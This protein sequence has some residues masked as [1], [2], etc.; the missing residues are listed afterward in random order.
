MSE[1]AI[2]RLRLPED[3]TEKTAQAIARLTRELGEEHQPAGDIPWLEAIVRPDTTYLLVAETEEGEIVAMVTMC[4]YRTQ[5]GHKSQ[6]EDV[7]T[8]EAY[9]GQGLCTRLFAEIFRIQKEQECAIQLT[10]RPS[11]IAANRLYQKLLRLVI[12]NVYRG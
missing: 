3:A 12:T 10:S 2:R 4:T 5:T 6:V 9:R 8:D 7:S 11:R 1:I